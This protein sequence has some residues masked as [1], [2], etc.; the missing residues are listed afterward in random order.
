[1]TW[2]MINYKVPK[3]M[4]LLNIK[5][6]STQQQQQLAG[7]SSHKEKLFQQQYQQQQQRQPCLTRA[8][9]GDPPP[10]P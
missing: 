6:V 8:P 4:S 5:G 1:M 3:A 9:K 10:D 7:G 2:N